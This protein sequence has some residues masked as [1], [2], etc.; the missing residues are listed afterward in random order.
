MEKLTE[1]VTNSFVDKEVKFLTTKTSPKIEPMSP[2]NNQ[3]NSSVGGGGGDGSRSSGFAT[4]ERSPDDVSSTDSSYHQNFSHHRTHHH[5]HQQNHQRDD[6]ELCR[7]PEERKDYMK[8]NNNNNNINKTHEDC[9][10]E[11]H[12]KSSKRAHILS[13]GATHLGED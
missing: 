9:G 2:Q 4:P 11:K 13:S 12:G 10:N 5:Q 8:L 3:N 1:F 6:R 7:S